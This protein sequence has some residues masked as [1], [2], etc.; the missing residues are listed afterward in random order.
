MKIKTKEAPVL[1]ALFL[2]AFLF[3]FKSSA[4]IA[5][6]VKLAS[7]VRT[8]ENV[9][10]AFFAFSAFFS[11]KYKI[12][13]ISLIALVLAVG[14][15]VELTTGYGWVLFTVLI[16]VGV[17]DVDFDLICKGILYGVL[18]GVMVVVTLYFLGFSDSGM[19][20]RGYFGLGFSHPNN[21]S[22][23]ILILMFAWLYL[24][25]HKKRIWL[26]SIFIAL[27]NYWVLGNRSVTILLGI[28]PVVLS[29]LTYLYKNQDSRF[30][31]FMRIIIVMAFPLCQ[32]FSI[33]TAVLYTSIP[34][35]QSL[36]L[37]LNS[38]IFEAY[39]NLNYFGYSLFGKV[40]EFTEYT[41]DPTR[42]MYFQYNV[43]DNSYIGVLIEMGIIASVIWGVVHYFNARI[44]DKDQEVELLA[45][46]FLCSLYGLMESSFRIVMV[47]F[48][49][50]YLLSRH[51]GIGIEKRNPNYCRGAI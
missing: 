29:M 1:L 33:A 3:C 18:V 4:L 50:L 27:C 51:C 16:V 8:I 36:S 2:I 44:L 41:F 32:F 6:N 26:I 15:L 24:N 12:K 22:E 7:I 9:P 35:L 21:F 49:L 30:C 43:L 37:I 20:R 34:A 14:L 19:K 13:E 45:I 47:D 38:R 28:Y 23:M 42:N 5:E 39:Y 48:T 11:K 46:Y 17:K 31:R 25:R 40:T 10:Y